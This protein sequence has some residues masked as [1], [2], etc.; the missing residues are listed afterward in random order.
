MF[1]TEGRASAK[2]V[3]WKHTWSV[4]EAARRALWLERNEE[5]TGELRYQTSSSKAL[6]VSIKTSVGN[7]ETLNFGAH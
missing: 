3:N 4:G 1:Q 6:H 7:G 2:G 5:E